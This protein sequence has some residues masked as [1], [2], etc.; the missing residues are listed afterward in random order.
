MKKAGS[1]LLNVLS[2]LPLPILYGFASI[3]YLIS[4]RL[5][6]YRKKVVRENLAHAFPALTHDQ[7]LAIEKQFYRNLSR[8]VVE[9]IKT[10][11]M[12]RDELL[13]RCIIKDNEAY[14]QLKDHPHSA[15]IVTAHFGNWEWAGQTM[16]LH[17]EQP[18]AVVFKPLKSPIVN[19]SMETIR[20]RF[21]NEIASMNQVMKKVYSGVNRNLVSC[22]LADQSPKTSDAGLWP[23][24]LNRVAPFFTGPEK[25]ARKLNLPV[26]FGKIRPLAKGYYEIELYLLTQNPSASQPNEIT[27]AYVNHLEETIN[28][29]P[30]NWLWSHRR[31]KRSGKAPDFD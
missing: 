24:F 12:S 1:F 13:Q 7:R 11:G 2:R 19:Q 30:A 20:S 22:F 4:Y 26:Y 8:W 23:E 3:L 25:I 9:I 17:L 18:V 29:Q 16:G 6:G 10:P 21:G 31:W 5:L 15:L 27:Q 14:R 28:E